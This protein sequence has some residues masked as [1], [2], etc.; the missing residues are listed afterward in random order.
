MR[1]KPVSYV[2][3][4]ERCKYTLQEALPLVKNCLD[5][6]LAAPLREFKLGRGE[7][8]PH[9]NFAQNESADNIVER[10][11]QILYL[12]DAA[13]KPKN[14]IKNSEDRLKAISK[15]RE[16]GLGGLLSNA[17]PKDLL[18]ALYELQLISAD[19][20]KIY[21]LNFDNRW[22]LELAKIRKSNSGGSAC[23]V[24]RPSIRAGG[25]ESGE[26]KRSQEKLR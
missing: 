14:R 19:E 18:P 20:L 5:V 22:Q 16:D 6:F 12:F 9:G 13:P 8:I 3:D 2:R 11:W 21:A 4:A 7:S 25:D 1:A 26:F 17:G 23:A 24:V 10:L 15:L